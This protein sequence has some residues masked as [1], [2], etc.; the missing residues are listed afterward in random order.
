MSPDLQIAKPPYLLSWCALALVSAYFCLV[1]LAL[2]LRFSRRT[3]VVKYEPPAGLSPAAATYLLERGVTE[4]PFA[5]ALVSM[6]AKGYLRIEQGPEDYLLTRVSPAMALSD[7]EQI[8]A[9]RL[10]AARQSFCLAETNKLE[11]AAHELRECLQAAL[12]P[13][14]ISTHFPLLVP[15]LTFSLWAFALVL[16]SAMPELWGRSGIGLAFLPASL[17][18][19]A[20]LS[21]IRTLPAIRY[22][23]E[24][25]LLR[26][27]PYRMRFARRD[28]TALRMAL[29]SVGSLAVLAWATSIQLATLFGAYVLINLIGSLALRAPT[30]AGHSQLEHLED[31]RSFLGA[32]DSDS[33]N[34]L[35]SPNATEAVAQKNWAWAVA[36]NIEHAWGEQFAA[37]VLNHLGPSSAMESIASNLPEDARAS[38]E[39]LDLHLQ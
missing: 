16:F 27:T 26:R 20:L 30:S 19:W 29:L 15:G 25:R 6:A 11:R 32:V 3:R 33:V 24:S 37:A 38:N 17:A 5:V 10:F 12:E 18:I 28:S 1:S 9:D 22:K 8:I 23:V 13:A 36:L 2:R 21:L 4:K 7:E 35:N 31:F 14:S 34:R 39:V